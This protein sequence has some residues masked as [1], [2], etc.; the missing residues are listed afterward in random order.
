M[1]DE[2]ELLVRDMNEFFVELEREVAP[3]LCTA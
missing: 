1:S 3:L 2:D